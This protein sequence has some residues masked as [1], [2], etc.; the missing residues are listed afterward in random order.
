MAPPAAAELTLTNTRSLAFGA[1]APGNSSGSA[2]LTPGSTRTCLGTVTCIGS[3]YHSASFLLEGEPASSYSL[4][5][6]EEAIMTN[7]NNDTLLVDDLTHNAPGALDSTGTQ[8][9]NVGA[10]LHISGS[11]PAGSYSGN[12]EITVEYE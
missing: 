11:Q 9:F 2:I 3:T 12:I 8:T 6:P 5:L 10:T 4:H 7:E 1:F